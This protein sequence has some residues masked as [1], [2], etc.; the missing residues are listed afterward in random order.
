MFGLSFGKL[1]VLAVIILVVWY[2]FKYVSRVEEVKRALRRA[3]EE[4]QPQPAR[5]AP[6]AEDLVKCAGCGAYVAAQGAA[7]CGRGECPWRR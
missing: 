2:G 5:R 4:K 1:V 7:P 3:A 6:A